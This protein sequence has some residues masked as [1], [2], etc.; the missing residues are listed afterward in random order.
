MCLCLP[1]CSLNNITGWR[2]STR[3]SRQMRLACGVE[4]LGACQQRP[5]WGSTYMCHTATSCKLNHYLTSNPTLKSIT[6]S[7]K[8]SH[9]QE[10]FYLFIYLLLLLLLL[11]TL[12]LLKL[13][14]IMSHKIILLFT[15]F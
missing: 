12:I 8:K 5:K 15:L 13:H 14:P 4:C 7:P 11:V 6:F 3:E 1:I 10:V 9:S 2:H